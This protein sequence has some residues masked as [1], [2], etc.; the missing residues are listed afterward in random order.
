[1]AT[2]ELDAET[3]EALEGLRFENYIKHF[4]IEDRRTAQL[5]PFVLNPVQLK[6]RAIIDAKLVAG[7]PVRLIIL[8]SR[9]M[10]VSTL[11]QATYAHLAFTTFLASITAVQITRIYE[12]LAATLEFAYG[13][14]YPL[15]IRPSSDEFEKPLSRAHVRHVQCAYSCV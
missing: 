14:K 1:V 15:V 9:R 8:K 2:T 11:I 4:R 5:V 10:G 13:G 7:E 6:L 12:R 3:R